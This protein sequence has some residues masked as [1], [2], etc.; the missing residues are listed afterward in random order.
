MT[1]KDILKCLES[2]YAPKMGW[3]CIPELGEGTGL[4]RRHIDLFVMQTWPSLKLC[5]IAFEI[6]VAVSDFKKEL[7][8]PDKRDPFVKHANEFYFATPVGLLDKYHDAIPPDCGLIEISETGQITKILKAEY[9]E[10]APN[11]GII[12]AIIRRLTPE[13]ASQIVREEVTP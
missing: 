7:S 10:H 9:K 11:W 8:D 5:R 3:L 12:V 6:K 13:L 4:S 2:Q 1:A